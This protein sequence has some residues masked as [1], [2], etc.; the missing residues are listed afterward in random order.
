MQK[1]KRKKKRKRKELSW[2][3]WPAHCTWK[4]IPSLLSAE[5]LESEKLKVG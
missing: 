4:A 3:I 2:A 1:K 5:N